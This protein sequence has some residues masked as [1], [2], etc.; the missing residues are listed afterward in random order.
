VVDIIRIIRAGEVLEETEDL[1]YIHE[2][3]VW[4]DK[5]VK[6]VLV[7]VAKYKYERQ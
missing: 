5:E 6:E 7:R 1:Q 4:Y 2:K 3:L